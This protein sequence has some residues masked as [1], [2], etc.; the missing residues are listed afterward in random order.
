MQHAL[1]FEPPARKPPTA[2]VSPRI[3]YDW[4][5]DANNWSGLALVGEAPGAEEVKRGHPFV[6]RSGQ[7]LDKMLEKAGIKRRD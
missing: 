5:P 3:E 6:G 4:P 2:P 7:L 1:K